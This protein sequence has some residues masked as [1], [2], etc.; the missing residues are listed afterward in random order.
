MKKAMMRVAIGVSFLCGQDIYAA[1]DSF[2]EDIKDLSVQTN[3]KKMLIAHSFDSDVSILPQEIAQYVGFFIYHMECD[4][5]AK[6]WAE[7]EIHQWRDAQHK[8]KEQLHQNVGLGVNLRIDDMCPF[9][10][11]LDTILDDTRGNECSLHTLFLRYMAKWS[12][13]HDPSQ[14]IGFMVSR[15][16]IELLQEQLHG[17]DISVA[18]IDVIEERDGSE[19]YS[20]DSDIEGWYGEDLKTMH[21]ILHTIIDHHMMDLF[22]AALDGLKEAQKILT[23][24]ENKS[25]KVSQETLKKATGLKIYFLNAM[26]PYNT[27]GN[28]YFMKFKDVLDKSMS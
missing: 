6:K 23:L 19:S 27:L 28:V 18:L 12:I 21:S 8:K 5:L 24:E 1:G 14:L 15:R 7:T 22:E 2:E 11:H 26:Q 9:S 13:I 10:S 20:L 3:K 25:S 17:Q 4:S 16:P